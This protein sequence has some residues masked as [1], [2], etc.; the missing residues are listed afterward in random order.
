M[1]IS[2]IGNGNVANQLIDILIKKN[3]SIEWIWSRNTEKT[4]ITAQKYKIKQS[5]SLE[6]LLDKKVDVII[7]SVK[8]DAIKIILEHHKTKN[9][10]VHTSGTVN[11]NS[12]EQTSE[13]IGVLYPLQT[14]KKEQQLNWNEI[15]IL[16]EAK[17]KKDEKTIDNLASKISHQVTNISSKQRE[18][19]H[20]AAV[21]INNFTNYLASLAYDF[22]AEKNIDFNI[23]KP[24]FEQTSE[25]ILKSSGSPYQNQTGPAKRLDYHTIE[26]H[27][28]KLQNNVNLKEIYTT[29]SNQIIKKEKND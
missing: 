2:I 27:I 8:D 10:I 20:V 5:I 15:P 11:M 14:F 9:L 18:D 28:D 16:I 26:K 13:H 21:T 24:L 22:L 29:F 7:V 17:N 3:V 12:L 19:I 4:K 23:L 25:K 6:E 1:K